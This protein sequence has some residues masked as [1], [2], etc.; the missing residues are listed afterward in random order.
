MSMKFASI[1][2]CFLISSF[3]NTK[4]MLQYTPVLK[5]LNICI[6]IKHF[7]E[8]NNTAIGSILC[9]ELNSIQ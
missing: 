7:K 5:C 9:I 4:A 2:V 1:T 8:K 3:F 6:Y